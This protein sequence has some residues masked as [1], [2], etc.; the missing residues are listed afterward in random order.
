[1]KKVFAVIQHT[2]KLTWFSYSSVVGS[3]SCLSNTN[4]IAPYSILFFSLW[5]TLR[6]LLWA[7]YQLLRSAWLLL[8]FKLCL[9]FCRC[10]IKSVWS[11]SFRAVPNHC[12]GFLQQARLT[13]RCAHPPLPSGCER[14]G[15]GNLENSSLPWSSK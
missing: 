6:I 12:Q 15:L 11:T 14:G 10:A 8:I 9:C 7:D 1:M 3:L 4:I 5:K 13:R 2:R